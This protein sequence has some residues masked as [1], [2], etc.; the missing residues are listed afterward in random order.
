MSTKK[1]VLEDRFEAYNLPLGCISHAIRA[2]AGGLPGA[3]SKVGLDIFVDPRRE[4][5]GIN[6]ISI[7]DSLVK[8]VEVDGDEFLY[9]KLPKITI[10]LIKGTAADRKG[11]ITFDD[12]FMSGDAL[13][14]CQAVKANRGKV[15]VQ[16]D[17]LVDTPSRPRNAIIP[18]CLVDA[19]VVAEPEKRNE[20]YTAL[21]GSFEIPY[22]DWYTW[23]EK[24][25]NVSTK[26]KKNSVTGNIIGKRAAQELRVDDIVNIGI[27]IPEMVS[28]YARK[29]GML[30]MVTLTV[31]SGGI[32]GKAILADLKEGGFL[33]EIEPLKH[34][35]GTCYRCHS[36]IEPMVSKQWFVKMEPLAKPAIESVEK[37]DIKFVP[38][39]FTKNYMNWMKNTR[40]W[41]ISRQLW[42]GHQIPA[43][44]CD[45]CG[46]TVVAKSA[47]CTCP[48]CGGTRLTQ[49]PDT[50]D[51][52]FSSALWPF[53]TL[54]WPNEESED[55]KYFYPTNTLVTGYDI[56]GFWVSRMIFSGLAYTGKAPFDTVCIHGIV[57]DSQ[58]RKMSKSLGNGI[59]PLE[60]IAQY[61]ADA[62]RFMLVDG[63]TP[64]NDMRYSEK[65]VEAAR[66]F[67][68]KLWNATRF[69]L[70]NLPEDFQPGLP[71][72]EKLDMSD[73]WVLTKLNQVAGAMSDNLDHYEMGLA[74]AKINSFIWD[75][76]CDWF[77]EIA[78]PRLNSG[79]AE[80][81][82]TARRVL[83]Y[84]LDK[85]LKLLHPFMPFI[86]E[87]LY[88][89]LPGSAETIMTQS[90]PTF[91]EA[92]NW[93]D[94]EEAF[95][96]VMDYIKAV[97]TMRT[98]MNVHP[99]KKTSMII[100]T[101]DPAPF[102]SAEVYLAKF[103]FA[104]D[105]TFTGK[106]EGSTDGMVQVSTHAARGF[107]PMMELIDRD[108][109]LARLNKE[110]AKA[111]KELAM[112]ENQL[113]NPKFVERAPAALVEDIR[114]KHTK[115]QDKLANIEQSIKALG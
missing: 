43:W 91:D 29:S 54:G 104:T 10:A 111:E 50:L 98:E 58:G 88:Q 45:D 62:L 16:V 95:E 99:A 6:R 92:H 93:A 85:A 37:G 69:V 15:I 64:G 83:V 42:W 8:H 24:I 78:K 110:K 47:P 112:F 34:E 76:Y 114:N 51:T 48:K 68:N 65:K 105:V 35:V 30:D 57:R 101:A 20:A 77:I 107:I 79:D 63:S 44:Y 89:A 32:G 14:I 28:R 55:L 33:K 13:S 102:Q 22:K 21:T 25:E 11:N 97:R 84:V 74:A 106:Y 3:L 75:V 109:E 49:D 96:K 90:W 115:S 71:S 72:E 52:W 38:E 36:T 46:E 61:G 18:G 59:D 40:D 9:Y 113:N 39:R 67:A 66:N 7:D 4:G 108:K 60:V 94:E 31:E 41:C 2:Q 23:S 12:M 5:P 56:I 17:R 80:Q 26:P 87:E 1:L 103:A 70:M 100:E 81:A 86:T 73:K 82:D 27:G 19:I 53:S